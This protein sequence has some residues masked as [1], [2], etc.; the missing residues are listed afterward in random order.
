MF[1]VVFTRTG[2]VELMTQ[3]LRSAHKPT[4]FESARS[5]EQKLKSKPHLAGEGRG[6]N[7][8]VLI[9]R[10]LFFGFNIDDENQRVYIHTVRWV[11]F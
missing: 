9:V 4:I 3:M 8:R 10:P 11:G 6:D 2:D 7:E 5:A 1:D